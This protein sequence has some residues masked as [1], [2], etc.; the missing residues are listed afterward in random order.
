MTAPYIPQVAGGMLLDLEHTDPHPWM[1]RSVCWDGFTNL[2]VPEQKAVCA[3][4]PVTAQCIQFAMDV[5][6]PARLRHLDSIVYG[7]LTGHEV[8]NVYRKRH[9]TD[10]RS[11]RGRQ[12]AA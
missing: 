12:V 6:G 5:E 9:H 4:C 3:D 2:D 1:E 7:G 8:Y 10:R 11:P